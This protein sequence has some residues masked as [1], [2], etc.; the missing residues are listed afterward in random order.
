ML[1]DDVGA[2]VAARFSRYRC[3][4]RPQVSTIDA[5]LGEGVVIEAVAL[6]PCARYANAQRV[7][8]RDVEHPAQ[9]RGIVASGFAF[10][11]AAETG[12]GLCG[13]N[14]D[15]AGGRIAAIKR[16]LRTA[17][18]FDAL[19]IEEFLFKQAVPDQRRVVE[20]DSDRWVA[21]R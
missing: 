14:V 3:A 18:H 12:F 20:T 2:E 16:A 1:P 17:Q 4:G 7:G 11:L 15:H 19:N 6:G 10:H 8:D 13:D 21:R 5:P 9:P